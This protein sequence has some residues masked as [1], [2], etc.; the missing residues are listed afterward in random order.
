MSEKAALD[1][2]MQGFE[3][4]AS[5]VQVDMFAADPAN[6]GAPSPL[7]A[8]LD[9][10]KRA[11]GRPAGSANKVTEAIRAYVLS[12]H[13]HPLQVMAEAYSMTPLDLAKRLGMEP[14]QARDKDGAPVGEPFWPNDTIFDLFKL[15]LGMAEAVAP[16]LMSKAPQ[17]VAVATQAGVNIAFMGVSVP[18]RAGP[19]ENSGAA[20][21]I[22]GDVLGVTIRAKSDE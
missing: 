3:G 9:Q 5:P 17:Q 14:V 6:G 21:A 1:Q 18:A 20:E 13:R 7:S 15:Q 11:P 4:E 12:Q 19:A 10:G 16:Y 22:A 8:S 2:A